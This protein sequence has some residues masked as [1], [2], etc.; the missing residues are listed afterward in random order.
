MSAGWIKF[1]KS[2]ATDPFVLAAAEQLRQRYGP[3][4]SF[5]VARNA[6]TGALV[7]L[8]AY[9][10]EHIRD[11]D[12]LPLTLQTLDAVVGIEGFYD[13]M[14]RQWLDKLDSGCL[15][16]RGYCEKNSLVAR[17][18]RTIK[19]NARVTRWRRTHQRNSNGV[20]SNHTTEFTGAGD[21]DQDIDK[22][23][24][25]ETRANCSSDR[26]RVSRETSPLT[27]DWWLDFKLAMPARAGDHRWTSARKAANARLAEG[28]T[29]DQMMEGCRRYRAF[30]DHLG[31]TG[32]EFV[33]QASTFLGPDRPFLEQWHLP[34]NKAEARQDKSLSASE[35]WLREQDGKDAAH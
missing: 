21:K 14:P 3:D 31:K 8:W 15:V 25:K 16:L 22:D 33:K 17:R 26:V 29:A 5:T 18:E 27:D 1:W 12:T 34:L 20:T 2:T 23:Q 10:D 30:C 4:F 13:L 28:Y 32:T 6:V 24:P 19:S 7:T 9:A 35:Q 11:D